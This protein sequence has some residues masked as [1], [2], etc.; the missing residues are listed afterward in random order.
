MHNDLDNARR[1][2]PLDLEAEDEHRERVLRLTIQLRTLPEQIA[3][4]I[5]ESCELVRGLSD[6]DSE[7]IWHLLGYTQLQTSID[8]AIRALGNC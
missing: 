4:I 6:E 3:A 1:K 2:L 8:P 5:D 7:D